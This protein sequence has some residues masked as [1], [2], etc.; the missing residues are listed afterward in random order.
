MVASVAKPPNREWRDGWTLVLSAAAGMFI[1]ALTAYSAGVFIVPLE[2]AYGWTRTQ[3]STGQTI[4]NVVA[5]AGSPIAG[6]LV[7]RYGPRRIALP[8]TALFLAMFGLL[9][10]AGPSIWSWYGFWMLLSLASLGTKPNVYTA[11]V[12]SRFDE[13]RGLALGTAVLGTGICMAITPPLTALFVERFDVRLAFVLLAASLAP[14]A[15][16]L[17]W[18]YFYGA[19]DV[20]RQGRAQRPATAASRRAALL[21]KPF[22]RLA[23]AGF[24]ASTAMTAIAVHLVPMLIGQGLSST[25]AAAIAGATGIASLFGRVSSGWL[26]DRF[27]PKWVSAAIFTLPIFAF[28]IAL[29]SGDDLASAL[30]VAA[31]FGFAL[32]GELDVIAYLTSR[33]FDTAHYGTL[34]GV[35][36][37]LLALGTGIGPL[38]AGMIYDAQ[39]SYDLLLYAAIPVM[40]FA[41]LAVS[42]V[43]SLSDGPRAR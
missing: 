15:L 28:A 8:G 18:R 24:A 38:L 17:L 37:G 19:S 42:T 1:S 5:V 40:A 16:P 41:A 23:M 22:L 6:M 3:I 9:G 12:A 30:V 29:H 33:N 13:H 10:L 25:T 32:G 43:R 27:P 4:F 21:S 2:Q 20:P 26:I 36:G 7:D 39:K 35:I 34:F 14:I 11:A 31:I